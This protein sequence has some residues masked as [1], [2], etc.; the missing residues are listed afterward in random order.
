MRQTISTIVFDVGETLIDE[1]SMRAGWARY[2]G[3][4]LE[5]FLAELD[6]SIAEGRHHHTVYRRFRPDFDLKEARRER[7]ARGERDIFSAADLY[8]DALPALAGLRKGG[9]RIGIAGNQPRAS[10]WALR[11]AGFE[12]DFVASS[13]AW[14][15]EKP[16]PAFFA[17]VA[18]AAGEPP[19]RIAYVGDRLDND[20]LPAR[21]AGMTAIFLVRGPW[22]RAHARRADAALAHCTIHGLAEIAALVR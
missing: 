13:E 12:A 19:G 21:A 5:A 3:V 4:T 14:G 1:T 18:E 22:G 20:V 2:F 7:T 6:L 16:S 9:F 8:P 10:E 11:E 17:K 15:V